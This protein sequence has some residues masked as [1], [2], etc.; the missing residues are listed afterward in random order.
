LVEKQIQAQ[1]PHAFIEQ[2]KGYN[3]FQKTGKIEVA[4]LQLNRRYIYPFRTYK[5]MESDPL[6]ALTNAMSKLSE[7]EGAAIQFIICPAGTAWQ[8]APRYT[9][10]EIQQG[11]NPQFVEKGHLGRILYGFTRGLGRAMAGNPKGQP[12]HRHRTCLVMRRQFS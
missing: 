11:K 1:Y 7:N 8:A 5:N 4:E 3:P 10:L 6:N 9:A 2:V 12:S